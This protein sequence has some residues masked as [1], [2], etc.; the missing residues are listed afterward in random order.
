MK[1]T[2]IQIGDKLFYKGQFN[3]FDFRVEQVTKHK[4]GYHAEP[5][6]HRM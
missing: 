4:V 1:A 2:E 6:E 5:Y 3:A